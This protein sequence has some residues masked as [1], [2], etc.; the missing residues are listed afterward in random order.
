MADPAKNEIRFKFSAKGQGSATL[1]VVTLKG[2]EALSR[3]FRFELTLVSSSAEIDFDDILSQSATLT[4]FSHDGTKAVPYH[5]MVCEFEQLHQSGGY[6]FYRA[7]LVPRL[8]KLSLNRINEVYLGEQSIFQVIGQVLQN[9]NLTTLDF[10][11]TLNS[12]SQDRLRSFVCQ[13]D[14]SSLDF[15]SRWLEHEGVYYHFDHEALSIGAEKLVMLDY[16]QA[17]PADILRL[18]YT[19]KEDIQTAMQDDCVHSLSCKQIPMPQSVTVQDYDFRHAGLADQLKGTAEVSANGHGEVLFYG[20]NLR[21]TDE[22]A[23]LARI[24]AQELNCREQ[25]FSGEATAVGLRCGHTMQLSLHYR[26]S[27][28]GNYLITEVEHG[29]SQAGVLL[30]GVN[31]PFNTDKAG[32]FYECKFKAIPSAKQFRPGRVTPKPKILGTLTATIDD[33]GTGTYAQVNEWGQYKV[34]LMYDLSD[35]PTNKGSAWV[36]MAT[37]YAG[38]RNGMHF[39]LLK[40]TEVLLGFMSGDPDQPVILGAVTNSENLNVVTDQNATY[41]GFVTAGANVMSANDNKGRQSILF[42]TPQGGTA[43]LIGAMDG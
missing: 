11:S 33:E 37:P 35:K 12:P 29:G 5:G 39:P 22:A 31:T 43:I 27:F 40:G 21:T 36:R 23:H 4:I 3:L 32:T 14:E 9:N 42:S 8:W 28:N 10:Q 26:S 1:D 17:Q 25:V 19:S 2:V 6:V 15:I 20:D 13:Y 7:V 38:P 24:R 16:Q 18:R 34:E 41:N 30:S